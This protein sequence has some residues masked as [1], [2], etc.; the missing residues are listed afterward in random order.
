MKSVAAGRLSALCSC[1]C[2]SSSCSS[3]EAMLIPLN[4]SL[5]FSQETLL[6]TLTPTP[7]PDCFAL[8]ASEVVTKWWHRLSPAFLH[9]Y[10]ASA[11]SAGE[12]GTPAPFL[13][14]EITETQLVLFIDVVVFVSIIMGK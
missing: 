7:W 3:C 4:K 5:V 8:R 6:P 2:S 11:G 1:S 12:A 14:C 9:P 10:A 13:H